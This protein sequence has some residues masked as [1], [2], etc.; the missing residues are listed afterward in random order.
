M[1]P[2]SPSPA[3]S[4]KA[5]FAQRAFWWSVLRIL[6]FTLVPILRLSATG[7]RTLPRKEPYLFL[8]NHVTWVDP[9]AIG[10]FCNRRIHYLASAHW[11]PRP[12]IG[13]FLRLFG[14][15][16]KMKFTSDKN[17]MVGIEEWYRSGEVVGVFPEG[18]RTW[19]GRTLPVLPHIGR[20][21]KR[22]DCPV[23]FCRILTG[24]YHQPRWAVYPR[25]APFRMAYEGP[26][27]YPAQATA[28]EI[29][30]DIQRRISVDPD[31]VP[32][33][34]WTFGWRMAWGLPNL[35]WA[36]PHCF[37][38]EGL[39]VD[40]A[41]GNAVRCRACGAAW[42]VDVASHLHPLAGP[43]V[44]STVAE[45]HSRL[46]EHFGDPPRADDAP[47]GVVLQDPC[48]VA[49]IGADGTRTILADGMLQLTPTTLRIRPQEG[50]D[51][52]EIPLASLGAV[53][54]EGG[55]TL[56]IRPPGA[57]VR[58]EFPDVSVVKWRTFLGRW[59]DEAKAAAGASS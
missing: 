33:P 47:P 27:H 3:P 18:R 55:A 26:I 57:L 20:L 11:Y 43:A 56:Q 59:R 52:W 6:T 5:T 25:W 30:A 38:L 31:A 23:V 39:R 44:E 14:T 41:D 48:T 9:F 12:L 36:C 28:E 37:A 51:A 42:R 35:L 22:L 24:Y 4:R 10:Y 54:V 58:L 29:E 32:V 40:P 1:Q 46:K 34:R 7:W 19:D 49:G 53:S 16:P 13:S 8:S 17:A 2:S 50:H 21:V 15:I 45:A